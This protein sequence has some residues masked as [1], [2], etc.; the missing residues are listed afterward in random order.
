METERDKHIPDKDYHDKE[1]HHISSSCDDLNNLRKDHHPNNDSDNAEPT[2][3]PP[4]LEIVETQ[5]KEEQGKIEESYSPPDFGK[6]C[7]DIDQFISALSLSKDSGSQPPEL[8][9][10]VEQF[11]SFA[12]ARIGKYDSRERPRKWIQL[13][14]EGSSSLLEVVDRIWKLKTSLGAFPLETMYA[15]SI[16]RMDDILQQ[17]ML[18]LEDEFREL[19]EDPPPL[20]EANHNNESNAKQSSPSSSSN[21]NQEI[22]Q[23]SLEKPNPSEENHFQE[24]TEEDVSNL[25]QIAKA[26]ISCGYEAECYHIYMVERRNALE[27]TLHNLGFEKLSL[28]DVQ[29][30]QWEQLGREI[31]SWNNIIKQCV[32][33]HFSGERKLLDAVFSGYAGIIDGLCSSIM[34]DPMIQLFNFAEATAMTK[35]SSEKLFKFLDIYET[36][37]D[38]IPSMDD[39]FPEQMGNELKSEALLTRSRLGE[40]LVSILYEL[41]DSIKADTAKT[42]VPGGA[43]HPLTSY[44]MNYL[45]YACDYK[46]T[47]EQ[48]FKDHQKIEQANSNQGPDYVYNMH[49]EL[50]GVKQDVKKTPFAAQIVKVMD[51]LDGNLET[52]SK[53]YKDPALSSIFMMNNG[54]YILKRIKESPELHSSMGDPWFRKRSSELRQYHRNYKQETW[55]KLLHCLNPEGL[56]S[57]NGKVMK[58]VL[59]E[60]FKS[61][62]AMFDE[63]RKKQSTWVI[64]DEQLQSEIRVSISSVV[65]PAYRSFLGRFSQTFTPGR[66]TEK[67]MKFQPED[68]ET[69]IE[70]LFDGSATPTGKKKP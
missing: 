49:R 21:P 9:E 25:N 43:V 19:L 4:Q 52:K 27:E 37:R 6:I 55:G 48:V 46:E 17:V 28:E 24:N 13:S 35:R 54:R 26:M 41:E 67:Y 11:A 60:R 10:V 3:S 32:N 51:L 1:H 69:S 42:P 38:I 30:M 39:V 7:E 45:K 57:A 5:I 16:N 23:G 53:L 22:N 70:E 50:S 68:V 59:K 44:I 65:I 8:P 12:E 62:N 40:V 61:F 47:L 36:L 63:I 58:P 29:K 15:L 18:Y 34:R 20:H 33:V 31:D 14:D 66:Q 64:S 56:M 2:K